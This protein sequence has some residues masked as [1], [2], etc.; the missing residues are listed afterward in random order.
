[1]HL[2]DPV[3]ERVPGPQSWHI[4]L[5]VAPTWALNVPAGHGVHSESHSPG[6]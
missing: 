1:M 5:S 4:S 3:G 6:P 2:P